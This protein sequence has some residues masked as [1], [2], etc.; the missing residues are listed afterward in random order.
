MHSH[1]S[2]QM[3]ISLNSL[4]EHR[5]QLMGTLMWQHQLTV[6]SGHDGKFSP[7]LTTLKQGWLCGSLA[8]MRF[9][10]QLEHNKRIRLTGLLMFLN[11]FALLHASHSAQ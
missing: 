2:V 11:G 4:G 1:S 9:C 6:I 8:G 7:L 5:V 10:S 3:V